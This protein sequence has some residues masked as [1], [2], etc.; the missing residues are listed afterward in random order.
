M[1]IEEMKFMT[2]HV[3]MSRAEYNGM[4]SEI[5]NLQNKI[6]AVVK[7][8]ADCVDNEGS[9]GLVYAKDILKILTAFADVKDKPFE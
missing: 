4:K 3:I 7:H 8:C 2:Q 6:D 9:S 5:M 1:T